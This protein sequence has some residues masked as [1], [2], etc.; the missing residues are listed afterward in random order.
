MT[1]TPVTTDPNTLAHI[2]TG[3]GGTVIPGQTFRF[4]LPVEKVKEA[5]PRINDLGLGVRRISERQEENPTKLGCSW[6]VV[7]LELHRR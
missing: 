3:L 5:I 6:G 1:K 7:T 2:V 4:D